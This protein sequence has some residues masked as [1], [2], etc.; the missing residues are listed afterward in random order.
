M[1]KILVGLIAA[2]LATVSFAAPQAST[3]TA[4]KAPAAQGAKHS[5]NPI[6]KFH[7]KHHAK[8][9]AGGVKAP[10]PAHKG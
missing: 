4:P 2:G 8:K 10:A 5:K 6:K 7:K 3:T 9:V 1:N